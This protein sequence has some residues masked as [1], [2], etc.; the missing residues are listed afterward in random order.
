MAPRARVTKS[1]T[2][3]VSGTHGIHDLNNAFRNSIAAGSPQGNNTG[4]EPENFNEGEEPCLGLDVPIPV[5]TRLAQFQTRV[6]HDDEGCE[7]TSPPHEA[8][9]VVKARCDGKGEDDDLRAPSASQAKGVGSMEVPNSDLLAR[10]EKRR[11]NQEKKE[12]QEAKE[13]PIPPM[14]SNKKQQKQ[15]VNPSVP[16]EQEQDEDNKQEDE[17][18]KGGKQRAKEAKEPKRRQQE[19]Q[20]GEDVDAD[21]SPELREEE[22][23]KGAVLLPQIQKEKE[24]QGAKD[25]RRRE[26]EQ[27][28]DAIQE[29]QELPVPK[30]VEAKEEKKRRAKQEEETLG[31]GFWVYIGF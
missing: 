2:V 24:R 7:E 27:E 12:N 5:V 19:P 11:A 21:E 17:V 29:D 31:L 25:K 26:K 6:Q 30:K 10:L 15:K 20:E 3:D 14:K 4:E 28:E 8:T 16:P 9:A 18:G 23:E 1:M 22:C 13:F